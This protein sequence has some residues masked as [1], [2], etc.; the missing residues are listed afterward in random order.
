MGVPVVSTAVG[1]IP[2]AVTDGVEGRLVPPGHPSLL[3][4]ALLDLVSDPDRR[5]VMSE[6]AAQRG[7]MF[8]AQRAVAR[9][10]DVYAERLPDVRG[11]RR[12]RPVG[13]R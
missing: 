6:A 9:V 5:M 12:T 4:T 3:A 2:E 10:E 13:G 11:S 7:R 1:G 8:D